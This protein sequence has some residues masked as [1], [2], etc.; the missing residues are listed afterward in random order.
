MTKQAFTVARVEAL[1][2]EPGKQQSMFWDAKV[3]GFGLRITASGARSY[4]F[5]SRLFG[6]TIR[7]TI[8]DA[9]TLDLGAARK[10]A[11][12]LRGLVDNKI[13]PREHRAEQ[14]AAHAARKVEAKRRDVTFGEAWDDYVK[15]R[16]P[17]WSD[18]HYQD[19]L[20]HA[21]EGGV[22][23][24]RQDPSGPALDPATA[25]AFGVERRAD[26]GL[27]RIAVRGTADDGGPVVPPLSRVRSLVRRHPGVS[28]GHS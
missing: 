26:C 5:E 17:A 27:A 15:A 22:A 14:A 13:D 20:Q 25:Q 11:V 10:E 19:H 7:T 8:G 2:C 28:R 21:A 12:R 24:N 3:A 6:N 18:R 1:Q 23:K 4:I 9:K 16:K